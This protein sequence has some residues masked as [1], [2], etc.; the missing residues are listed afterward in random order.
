MQYVEHYEAFDIAD[1]TSTIRYSG[2]YVFNVG[3]RPGAPVSSQPDWREI[4]HPDRSFKTSSSCRGFFSF[5]AYGVAFGGCLSGW[6][7][8][9]W[10]FPAFAGLCTQIRSCLPDFARAPKTIL[11]ASNYESH[12]LIY[13]AALVVI[14]LTAELAT[15]MTA[16]KAPAT[17]AALS[18]GLVLLIPIYAAA[19]W[20]GPLKSDYTQQLVRSPFH[21]RRI[22]FLYAWFLPSLFFITLMALINLRATSRGL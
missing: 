12:R 19:G 14:A 22:L 13:G 1:P 9:T 15:R 18:L 16:M 20:S 5:D 3:M 11:A 21:R 2:D 10:A 4:Y 6:I 17:Y 8:L 7:I